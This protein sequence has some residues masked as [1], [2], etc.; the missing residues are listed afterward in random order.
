MS[1]KQHKW[2]DNLTD[3]CPIT[4][5]PLST[6]PYPPFILTDDIISSDG[7]K[8]HH[9]YFDGLALATYIIYIAREFCKSTDT[10]TF[11]I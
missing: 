8:E 11:D 4:L 2:W 7:K 9:A 5:E 3:E 6:L 10:G 1:S